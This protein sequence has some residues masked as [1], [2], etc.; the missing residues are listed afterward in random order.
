MV[1]FWGFHIV[2]QI[3]YK[4]FIYSLHNI[5]PN[6]F[7]EQF[8]NTSISVENIDTQSHG[9]YH[10]IYFVNYI[11]HFAFFCTLILCLTPF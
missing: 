9:M 11:P 2:D 8:S 7:H 5:Y 3:Y 6:S 10:D 1:T 4:N